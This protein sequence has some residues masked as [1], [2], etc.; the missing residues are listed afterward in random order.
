MINEL[1]N[2]LKI[3]ET[4]L[5]EQLNREQYIDRKP[6]E[7]TKINRNLQ[8]ET[9]LQTR[10]KRLKKVMRRRYSNIL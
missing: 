7:Q 10:L 3:E 9:T 2:L 6:D 8:T 4:F 1:N 5:T